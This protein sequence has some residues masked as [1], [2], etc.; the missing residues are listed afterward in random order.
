ML[1]D[2]I[3]KSIEIIRR[4]YY[5]KIYAKEY[6]RVFFGATEDI[7]SYIDA[8]NY[9]GGDAL[10]V[11]ASG[12]QFF[13]LAFKGARK[14]DLFEINRLAYFVFHLRLAALLSFNY[15]DYLKFNYYFGNLQRELKEI[16]N[17]LKDNM[18][19]DV[20][21]YYRKL[22]EYTLKHGLLIGNLYYA[23]RGVMRD[24]NYY[25]RSEDNYNE[26]KKKIREVEF[27]IFWGDIRE[28]TLKL[29]RKYTL[30]ILSNIAD[31]LGTEKEILTLDKFKGYL[32]SMEHLLKN[33][34]SVIS[35]FFQ[36]ERDYIIDNANITREDLKNYDIHIVHPEDRN[37]YLGEGFLISRVRKM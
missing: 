26:L 15:Q 36:I 21:I 30:I 8:V 14:V 10:S 2:A 27:R 20:Y 33:S 9:A 34:G 35:Y 18:P 31:S 3:Q 1:D 25:L 23:P 4:P 37:N 19:E 13:N 32:G 29:K 22:Q 17:K 28:V 12:D 7:K 5:E 16:C 11:M 6:T 24:I